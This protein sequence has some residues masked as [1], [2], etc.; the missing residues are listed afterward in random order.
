MIQVDLALRVLRQSER[1]RVAGKPSH[2]DQ[3]QSVATAAVSE[4]AERE[5][6]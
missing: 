3:I 6:Y 2:R 4:C 1:Y 5:P